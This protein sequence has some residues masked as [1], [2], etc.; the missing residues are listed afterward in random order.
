MDPAPVG[1]LVET[2]APAHMKGATPASASGAVGESM[3]PVPAHREPDG[4]ADGGVRGRRG[5][6]RRRPGKAA[7]F[8]PDLAPDPEVAALMRFKAIGAPE[9]LGRLH[10][11]TCPAYHPDT[12]AKYHPFADL[13]GLIDSGAWQKRALHAAAGP[14]DA[15][16]KGQELWQAA[17]ALKGAD[18]ADLNDWRAELHKAFRDANPGP[19][20]YPTPGCVCPSSVPP[21]RADGRAG[22]Q[23]GG[24][25]VP[26]LSPQVASGPPNAQLS[27]GP[28]S[29][30]RT[31]PRPRRT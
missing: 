2:P 4:A 8:T 29:R 24:L 27:T 22:G 3:T 25:R 23:R 10:D 1:E 26:E 6:A 19:G 30:A 18:P 15:A 12:V 16:L 9:D 11:L 13:T 21:A 20:S 17:V 14:L 7:R 31:P 5:H 28:R